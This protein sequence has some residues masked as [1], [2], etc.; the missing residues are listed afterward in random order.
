MQV[1]S[2]RLNLYNQSLPECSALAQVAAGAG[3]D[4]LTTDSFATAKQHFSPYNRATMQS[5]PFRGN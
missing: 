5:V 2:F 4:V 3:V 1:C